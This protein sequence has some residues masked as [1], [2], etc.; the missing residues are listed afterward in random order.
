MLREVLDAAWAAIDAAPAP[1]PGQRE[2]ACRTYQEDTSPVQENLFGDETPAGRPGQEATKPA[3][4]PAGPG[5]PPPAPATTGSAGQ[6]AGRTAAPRTSSTPPTLARQQDVP[7]PGSSPRQVPAAPGDKAQPAPGAARPGTSSN[8]LTSDDIFRGLQRLPVPGFADLICA[9]D[10]GQPLDSLARHLEPRSGERTADEPD[11]GARETVTCTPQ[12]VRIQVAASSGT[13]AGL[14][15]WPEVADWLRPGLSP[16]NLQIMR[17]AAQTRLRLITANASFRAAGEADLAASA[18][19]ELRDLIGAAVSAALEAARSASAGRPDP[20]GQQPPPADEAAVLERIGHLACALPAWPPQPQKPVSQVRAGDI[21]GHPGYK[22]QPFHVSAPPRHHDGVIEIAGRLTRPGEG[23][24]AGEI[25]WTMAINGQADPPVH[26]VPVPARSLRPGSPGH[27]EPGAGQQGLT[28]DSGDAPGRD[29]PQRQ[30]TAAKG[31]D[32]PAAHG[33]PVPAQ[34]ALPQ[35]ATRPSAHPSRYPVKAWAPASRTAPH[36]PPRRKT[37]CHQHQ[38]LSLF[39]QPEPPPPQTLARHKPGQQQSA[40]PPP[41]PAP[42]THPRSCKN[43]TTSSERSSSIGARPPKAP[44]APA[45]A[46]QISGQRSPAC[47]MPLNCPQTE[48]SRAQATPCP[49]PRLLS[50]RPPPQD[51]IGAHRKLTT[52]AI[53][54]PR[55]LTSGEP[56]TCPPRARIPASETDA[57]SDRLVDQAAAEAQAC[58]RWYRDTPEWQRITAIS[59]AARDLLTT[60]RQASGEYWA[61]I[62]QDIR[63]RGFVRTVAARASLAVSGAA[64]VLAGRLEKAGHKDTRIWR[65]ASGLH[66]ATATFADRVH[67]VHPAT[68]PR[69]DGRSPAHHQ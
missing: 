52:S 42:Q 22:L 33:A 2:Q 5:Q 65:A 54:A 37:P 47:V 35:Q 57:A 45:L 28:H 24:P 30:G 17:Q 10:D 49:V 41:N 18:E 1:T 12:G 62:R 55:S 4:D 13:R 61:E 67:E 15:A 50:H 39:P 64:H 38:M 69:Q 68:K 11:A 66:R 20:G 48:T 51:M 34:Q 29:A 63:V 40:R 14:L 44:P 23:E 43:L 8:P 31:P 36:Q 3:D 21:V 16:G 25:T 7:G 9:I 19:L 58:A 53:S 59:R 6:P 46:S 60:I 56:S 26:V 27:T 32:L